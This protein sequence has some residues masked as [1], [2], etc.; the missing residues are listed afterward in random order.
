M[1]QTQIELQFALGLQELL[2]ANQ[3]YV[4]RFSKNLLSALPLPDQE[5]WLAAVQ[6][7]REHGRASLSSELSS[8]H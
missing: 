1:L 7:A 6:L 2:L 8:M 3:V 5:R 4:T